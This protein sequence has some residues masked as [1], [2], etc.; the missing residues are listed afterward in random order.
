[1]Q[2]PYCQAIGSK[3]ARRGA[4][5]QPVLTRSKLLEIERPLQPLPLLREAT[6]LDLLHFLLPGPLEA[7]LVCGGSVGSLE[8]AQQRHLLSDA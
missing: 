4:A 5:S 3:T 1:M 8:N 2:P 6:L 7:L